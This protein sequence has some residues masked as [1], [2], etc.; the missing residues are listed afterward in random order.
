MSPVDARDPLSETLDEECN[1]NWIRSE[2]Q[3]YLVSLF[4][5]YT[6][7]EHIPEDLVLITESTTNPMS[8]ATTDPAIEDFNL[9]FI[10]A[11]KATHNFMVW[12]ENVM[13]ELHR[14]IEPG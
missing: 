10:M 2:F 7:T 11:W 4:S 3:T 12:K 6:Y 13:D 1:D 14:A 5:T 9:S 8:K